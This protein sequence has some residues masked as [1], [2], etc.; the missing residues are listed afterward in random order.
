MSD[1]TVSPKPK[2]DTGWKRDGKATNL[3]IWD[4]S[5]RKQLHALDGPSGVILPLTFSPDGKWL[6]CAVEGGVI[7]WC[8]THRRHHAF[9]DKYG[10]PHSPHL[11]R[12]TGAKGVLV[13]LWHAHVGWLFDEE[14]SDAN[15]PIGTG[16]TGH[17]NNF[18]DSV[19]ARDVARLNC[20]IEVGYRSTILPHLAN[21]SYRLGRELRWD[22]H[23]DQF[24]ADPEA[25]R[26]LHR[27]D[28]KGYE[29]PKIA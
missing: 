21:L 6:A 26:M 11:A 18:I 4:L 15:N 19:M 17:F 5:T 13:G 7:D 8:A 24:A 2:R 10:D 27:E 29:V 28:R 25:N 3:Q 12:A 9:A 14:K 1:L 23:K 16:I 20:E 22:A